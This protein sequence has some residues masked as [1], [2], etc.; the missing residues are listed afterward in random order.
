MFGSSR[1]RA[2][3]SLYNAADRSQ[4]II[5]FDLDGTVRRANDNFLD[6]L[7]YTAEEV[8]GKH[9]RV[10]VHPDEAGTQ[11]YTRFWEHLRGGNFHAGEFRRTHK[12]G[13]DVWI[14]A[15][16]NPIMSGDKPVG[17]VKFASVITEQKLRDSDRQGQLDALDRSMARIEFDL[18]GVVLKANDNF[19]DAVGYSPDEVIGKH[20]SM[21][22]HRGEAD[23]PEYREHWATLHA[24]GYVAGEFLRKR[25]D[26]SDLWLNA[27][28]NAVLDPAGRPYK[29]VKFAADITASKKAMEVAAAATRLAETSGEI[30]DLSAE[31][32]GNSSNVAAKVSD[33][34]AASEEVTAVLDSL[35]EATERLREGVAGAASHA[36]DAA[37]VA[38]TAVEVANQ[39]NATV[40]EL[41]K[42]SSEIGGVVQLI[43]SIAEQTNLLALNASIEAARAGDA[44][45]GFA[46]V[47]AEVKALAEQTAEATSQIATR[48]DTTQR[49]SAN[50]ASA[51]DEITTTI[52]RINDLQAAITSAMQDQ[53]VTA[54][55]MAVNIA[56]AAQASLSIADTLTDVA[57]LAELASATAE[58]T[59]EAARR[60][61]DVALELTAMAD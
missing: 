13:S 26:G 46:V 17:V 54:S 9:H 39:T 3:E 43:T 8:V 37:A 38:A 44:G 57:E 18:E 2:Y 11:E 21:F 47:A 40:E 52:G 29:V 58:Q 33:A 56:E 1:S 30:S 60:T 61:N 49:N 20:H 12:D 5:E 31:L 4:A 22:M 27:T 25:K 45:R 59:D 51:V 28:Y 55:D 50:A 36:D 34:A 24:G 48:I 10:F 15:T 42:S 16:Y 14:Q 19:C 53:Q 35:A 6:A 23:T 7:G 32:R 41:A